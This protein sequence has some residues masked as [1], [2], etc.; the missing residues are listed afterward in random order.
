[1]FF[2]R[3]L[4]VGTKIL[5]GYV[6]LLI[7]LAGIAV[8]AVSRLHH[9]NDTVTHLADEL[10]LERHLADSMVGAILN[11]RYH[12]MMYIYEKEA[13]EE[14]LYR[15][16]AREFQQLLEQAEKQVG[17]QKRREMLTGISDEVANYQRDFE[18]VRT[19]IADRDRVLRDILDRQGPLA[20]E[21][22]KQLEEWLLAE[23]NGDNRQLFQTARAQRQLLLMRLAVFKYLQGGEQSWKET[24]EQHYSQAQRHLETLAQSGLRANPRAR[25]FME[26]AER[27]LENYQQGFVGLAEDYLKQHRLV[28]ESLHEIGARVRETAMNMSEDVA[29]DFQ[30]ANQATHQLVTNTQNLLL[31]VVFV[32]I[33]GGLLLGILISRGITRP[34]E[35]AVA[36][37]RRLSGGELDARVDKISGEDETASLCRAMNGMAESLQAIIQELNR[38]LNL[39]AGGDMRVQVKREFPGDF[40]QVKQALNSTTTRLHRVIA[41]VISATGQIST[42]AGQVSNTSQSLAQGN[43]EQ[44]ATVEQT[45]TSTEQMSASVS[46]NAQHAEN[47]D[48]IARETAEKAEEGGQ[49]VEDTVKAM[50]QIAEKINIIEEI[51][52]QTNL[53]ALNAAIEA[54]RAGEHGRG[55]SVVAVEVRKLAERSQVAARE[56]SQVATESVEI[57]ERAGELLHQIV[58]AIRQTAN[59]VQEIAAAS[60]EQ[61][62]GIAQIN[63]AMMQLDKVTQGNAA[64]AEQLAATSEEMSGQAGNLKT[65]MDY[66]TV[67]EEALGETVTTATHEKTDSPPE[68]MQAGKAARLKSEDFESF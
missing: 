33:L 62:N 43:G 16:A 12:A 2:F 56:I 14:R 60:A 68:T 58:P 49:A 11:I 54:A 41:E 32:A 39:M 50:R 65:M 6:L 31:G 66:F 52:Y 27:A 13:E 3:K 28:H 44:A 9:I 1:M 8:L 46:Q 55:F 10:A 37:S 17:R 42:A 24:F 20:D 22:L 57:S 53:L 29:R 15:E 64:A 47:T 63:N 35:R 30:V 21:N 45:T 19:A 67:N 5:G 59:L 40:V 25:E 48:D 61:N 34:L 26:D 51:A 36:L 38:V 18:A 7:L 4:K 23:G